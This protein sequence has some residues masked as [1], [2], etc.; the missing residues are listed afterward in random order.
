VTRRV[1]ATAM[2]D[3]VVRPAV[4]EPGALQVMAASG[5]ARDDQVIEAAGARV[6]VEPQAAAYPADKVLDAPFDAQGQAHFSLGRQ[7]PGQA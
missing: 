6:F 5:P 2:A 7:R 1:S 3:R 4:A